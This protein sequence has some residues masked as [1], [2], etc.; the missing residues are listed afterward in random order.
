MARQ[1]EGLTAQNETSEEI[2]LKGRTEWAYV[3]TGDSGHANVEIELQATWGDT[4]IQVDLIDPADPGGAS[5]AK[6]TGLNKAGYARVV[7]AQSIRAKRLDA[8]GTE[9]EVY[10][11]TMEPSR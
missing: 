10:L 7:G 4:P 5:I 9:T 6:I 11:G 2:D 8:N 3:A 1:K